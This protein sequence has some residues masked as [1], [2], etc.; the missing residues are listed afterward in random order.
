MKSQLVVYVLAFLA[1]AAGTQQSRSL[2]AQEDACPVAGTTVRVTATTTVGEG[3]VGGDAPIFE[4]AYTVEIVEPSD[5]AGETESIVSVVQRPGGM[6]GSGIILDPTPLKVGEV[7]LISSCWAGESGFDYWLV[8]AQE[9]AQ[10]EPKVEW[11]IVGLDCESNERWELISSMEFKEQVGTLQ[12]FTN[13]D[14]V[15]GEETPQSTWYDDWDPVTRTK[16][17]TWVE[18]DG[19]LKEH[20]DFSSVPEYLPLNQELEIGDSIVLNGNSFSVEDQVRWATPMDRTGGESRMAWVLVNEEDISFPDSVT[21]AGD[22]E[23]KYDEELG[24]L[25]AYA[26]TEEVYSQPETDA[27]PTP[28]ESSSQGAFIG[29][30]LKSLNITYPDLGGMRV[31]YEPGQEACNRLARERPRPSE[32]DT[33]DYTYNAADQLTDLEGTS[34]GYD[35]NGNQTDRGNDTFEYDHENRLTESVIGGVT[36]TSVYNGNGLRMSHTVGQTTTSYVWD[37]ASGLPVVLQDGT[38][39]YVYGL[40]LISATDGSGDQTYF[41]YDGLGSVTDLTD[42]EGDVVDGYTYDVFGAIRSQSGASDNP[43]LFTGEQ[44]DSDEGLY[45]LRARYYDSAIGRFLSHDPAPM[46]LHRPEANGHYSY[47]GNNPI[48][49]IDPS[50]LWCPRDPSDCD[51]RGLLDPLVDLIPE[52]TIVT[53]LGHPISFQLAGTCAIYPEACAAAGAAYPV[54]NTIAYRLYSDAELKEGTMDRPKEG[55]AFQHCFWSGLITL[56]AGGHAAEEVTTHYEASAN[57][58]PDER[59]YDLYNNKRGREFAQTIK[60]SPWGIEYDAF[61]TQ[62]YCSGGRPFL[63]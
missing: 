60:P 37:V 23:L 36:S 15:S 45:Y 48:S 19:E 4:P 20:E 22:F 11:K 9:P 52:G 55:D 61:L 59:D 18:E 32:Q 39:T 62:Q 54:A 5:R 56:A 42:D 58:N 40:D 26:R 43:W 47:V 46:N 2:S 14:T 31:I 17:A 8:E 33:D 49:R 10:L 7:Y 41:L 12:R 30:R 13:T 34:F 24:L 50:G 21:L 35:E 1:L 57:N 51:P 27:S 16:K 44:F 25:V 38:N 53:I 29:Y 3:Y 28:G 63:P 6:P